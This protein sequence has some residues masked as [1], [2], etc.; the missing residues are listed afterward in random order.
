[1]TTQ[2]VVL[3]LFLGGVWTAVPL[4]SAAGS[5]V[6]RGMEAGGTWPSPSSIETEINNDSLNYDPSNP[7]STIYGTV[8]RNT[9]ARLKI[10]GN[11]RLWAEAS[12][13]NPD[14]TIEH[15]SGAGKGRA[16]TKL[17]AEGVLRRLGL[18]EEP[19]RS[20][21]YRTNSLRASQVGHWPLEDDKDSSR[22][23]NTGSVF[24]NRPGTIKG[25]AV[26]GESEAPDGAKTTAKASSTSQMAGRFGIGSGTAGWQVCLSFKM[27]NI[28]ASAT[29]GTLLQWHT[30]QGYRYTLDV[31]NTTFRVSVID[32]FGTSLL[33]S[34]VLFSGSEPDQ[35]V[36]FRVKVTWAAG[37]V[38]VEPAW[39][40][41]GDE[42]EGGWTTT[43]AATGPGTLSHWAQN[44]DTIVDGTWFSHIFGTS[45]VADSLVGSTAQ[46]IFNG[47][48]GEPAGTRY[49]RVC[50]ENGI[51]RFSITSVSSA[52][53]TQPMGPQR[54]DTLISIL[55]EIVETDDCRIDDERFDIGLTMTT[56]RAM[57]GQ[58]PALTLTYPAQIKPPFK[59]IIGDKGSKNRVT[60][61]NRDGGEETAELLA[62]SMSVLPPPAGIGEAK[63]SVDVNVA[64]ETAQLEPLADWHLAKGTLERPRY[65]AVSVDLLANPGLETAV[66]G[67]R[68]G[69]MIRVTGYEAEPIDLL[70]VGIVSDVGAVEHTVTFKT[71]PYEPYRTGR[72]DDGVARYDSRTSTVNAGQTT[73]STSWATAATDANDVW[74]TTSLPYDWIVA[75]ERVTVTA[76]TAPAGTGPYTQTATVVRSV[77]GVVKAQAI[78]NEIHIANARRWGL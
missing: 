21:M 25:G 13:W 61:K 72:Y 60:V 29:Y 16:W 78:G 20:P 53:D 5:I 66:N 3:E 2:G 37:T 6:T 35:W 74:S 69:N 8:G 42:V 12:Q 55:K 19:L 48:R 9:R 18:W 24:P 68:E 14:R 46:K 76:I 38:T 52:A 77:N 59:K 40:R 17:T 43:F 45:G 70:V 32:S 56:R 64:D 23:A 22:L 39:Y 26:L 7:T 73:T 34:A 54:A 1:V 28:P 15:V 44:G 10:N 63:G 49:L 47:Y 41:Q 11:T 65:D 75:G 27:P 67:V 57:L 62:G 58:T 30:N 71:E 31:N 51:T 50:S 4:Y 33:S 36:T